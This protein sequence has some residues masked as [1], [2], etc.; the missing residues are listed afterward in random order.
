M[1]ERA[2]CERLAEAGVNGRLELRLITTTAIRNLDS[3]LIIR[4][5]YGTFS[6]EIL[7]KNTVRLERL[8]AVCRKT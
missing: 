5:R 6:L 8:A 1:D 4:V 7:A 2:R 3:H